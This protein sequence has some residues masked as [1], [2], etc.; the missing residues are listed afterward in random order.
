MQLL[1]VVFVDFINN[2]LF[3]LAEVVKLITGAVNVNL[4]S[5][6]LLYLFL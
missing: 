4:K 1:A 2:G 3:P 6:Y 5:T